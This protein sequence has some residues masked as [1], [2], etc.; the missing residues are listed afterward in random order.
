MPG[1]RTSWT[2]GTLNSIRTV[3][4]P[5]KV[6]GITPKGL[7]GRLVI[8]RRHLKDGSSD[9]DLELRAR[10]GGRDSTYMGKLGVLNRLRLGSLMK[11][12]VLH[13]VRVYSASHRGR[14]RGAKKIT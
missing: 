9:D 6:P 5:S 3:G 1:G 7:A 13:P 10:S 2:L 4:P 8:V 12:R 14:F 11:L